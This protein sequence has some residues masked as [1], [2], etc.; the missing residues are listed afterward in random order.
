MS[1]GRAVRPVE[2]VFAKVSRI[3]RSKG[4]GY[5]GEIG[6]LASVSGE[7]TVA[8]KR[9]TRMESGMCPR[10]AMS[11]TG[12]NWHHPCSLLSTNKLAL[13][14]RS[15]LQCLPPTPQAKVCPFSIFLPS[16]LMPSFS[17]SPTITTSPPYSPN[18]LRHITSAGAL[19]PQ[20]DSVRERERKLSAHPSQHLGL[21]VG[22]RSPTSIPSSPTSV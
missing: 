5:G 17:A 3:K 7:C 10:S 2:G 15:Y 9:L 1:C 12:R 11:H 22:S 8:Y 4:R 21:R 18:D 20:K 13:L 14:F 19:T 6:G 16:T